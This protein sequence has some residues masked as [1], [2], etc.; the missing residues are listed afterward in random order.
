MNQLKLFVFVGVVVLANLC[1]AQITL[2]ANAL[3]TAAAGIIGF[4]GGFLAG[5]ILTN[6]V[7]NQGRRSRPRFHPRRRYFYR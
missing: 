5:S 2:D 1:M 7:N 4:K 6:A 3:N